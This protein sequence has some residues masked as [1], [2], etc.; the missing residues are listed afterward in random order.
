MLIDMLDQYDQRVVET[1]NQTETVFSKSHMSTLLK[2]LRKSKVCHLLAIN[3][4]LTSSLKV[5]RHDIVLLWGPKLLKYESYVEV[6]NLSEQIAYAA[7]DMGQFEYA[8]SII[9]DLEKQFPGSM[10]VSRILGM[11][12]EAQAQFPEAM[13]IYEDV[14][15]K[16]ITNLAIMKRK[17]HYH[18]FFYFQFY[19]VDPGMHPQGNKGHQS[20]SRG[21]K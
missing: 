9:D 12:Y 5:E 10:R 16:D 17:V 21:N 3:N 6:W 11:F 14:L 7:I 19:I 8:K 4:F 1:N 13:A 20:L 15:K 18:Y 2:E